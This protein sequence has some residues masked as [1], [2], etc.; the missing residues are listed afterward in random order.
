MRANERI[1][2]EVDGKRIAQDTADHIRAVE[3]IRKRRS[4]FNLLRITGLVAAGSAW[5]WFMARGD[6]PRLATIAAIATG[7][8]FFVSVSAAAECFRLRRQLDAVLVLM[9]E[10]LKQPKS[11]NQKDNT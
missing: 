9:R 6:D 7:V 2:A 8:A 11:T 4:P 1:V 5:G 10:Q 3:E